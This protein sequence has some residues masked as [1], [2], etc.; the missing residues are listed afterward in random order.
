VV[1]RQGADGGGVLMAVDLLQEQLPPLSISRLSSQEFHRSLAL[2][3][4]TCIAMV[5]MGEH[6][7]IY[8]FLGDLSFA[9]LARRAQ[10]TIDHLD[11]RGG[12]DN[13]VELIKR[14]GFARVT[15]LAKEP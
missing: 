5:I 13:G 10:Q 1:R 3:L 15:C 14:Q 8:G 6:E 4:A 11:Q 9:T 2:A 7:Q 12:P